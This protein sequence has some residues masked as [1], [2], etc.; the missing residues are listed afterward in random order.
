MIFAIFKQKSPNHKIHKT[1]HSEVAFF[2]QYIQ[3]T[4]F[5]SSAKKA[6]HLTNLPGVGSEKGR[7]DI[8]NL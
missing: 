2:L 4:R 7:S 1:H 8:L 3:L 6:A 5:P